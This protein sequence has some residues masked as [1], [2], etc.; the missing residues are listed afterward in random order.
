MM[1]LRLYA[2]LLHLYPSSFYDRFGSEMLDVF[3]QAWDTNRQSLL[4]TMIFCIWE[5]AGLL[6]SISKER[7]SERNHVMLRKWFRWY[8]I[9]FWLFAFSVAVA[10]VISLLTWGYIVKPTSLFQRIMAPESIALI[11][12]D[13][14]YYPT[15]IPLNDVPYLM[16]PD[17]PPSQILTQ[18]HRLTEVT[19]ELDP[20]FTN[21][22]ADALAAERTELGDIG[23]YKLPTDIKVV[24]GECDLCRR[25]G[26]Q[27]QADGSLLITIPIWHG[28][29]AIE[30]FGIDHAS[31]KDLHYYSYLTPAAYL[32]RGQALDGTPLAFVGLATG[33]IGDDPDDVRNRYYEYVFETSNNTLTL[34]EQQS[35]FFNPYG[36]QDQDV[37]LMRTILH[38]FIPLIVFFLIG[39]SV[40]ILASGI[41]RLTAKRPLL[42]HV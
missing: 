39:L 26:V 25:W 14:D 21:Q 10:A 3:E 19:K 7:W 24:S 12:F 33:A 13:E 4:M 20:N 1:I 42:E 29:Q 22:L 17:F 2:W 16:T 35:Y 40:K 11:T 8:L 31:M 28:G 6:V 23:Y 18:V 32:V 36:T 34:L 9:P 30:E 5:F 41:R 38:V 37:S 27:A 15:A